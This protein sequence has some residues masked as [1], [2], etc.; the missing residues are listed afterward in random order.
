MTDLN[1][2]ICFIICRQRRNT[3]SIY[4]WKILVVDY[5]EEKNST[6][7]NEHVDNEIKKYKLVAM[8]KLF[9]A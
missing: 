6:R 2:T 1:I 8:Y 3:V 5:K 9:P 4:W 7:W